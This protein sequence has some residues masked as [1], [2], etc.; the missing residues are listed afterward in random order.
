MKIH[1]VSDLH[2]EFSPF[3][4]ERIPE[5]DVTVF[6]GDIGTGEDLWELREWFKAWLDR[7]NRPAVYVLGNHEFYHSSF[8]EVIN[9]WRKNPLPELY[10]LEKDKVTLNGVVFY[11]C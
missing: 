7:T 3:D 9:F 10:V 1:F 4:P 8:S 5:A 6:G 2:L 11:G